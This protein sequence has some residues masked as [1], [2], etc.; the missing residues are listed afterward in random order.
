MDRIN[1]YETVIEAVITNHLQLAQQAGVQ[2]YEV[3]FDTARHRYLLLDVGWQNDERSY[4]NV[5]HI[6]LLDG[7][8]WIQRDATEEGVVDALLEAGIP[9]E[10]IVLG[11]RSPFIRQFTEFA[12]A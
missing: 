5:I 1:Q 4:T 2:T 12:V 9:K 6:D 3:V 7:K 11:Y 8:V 10:H